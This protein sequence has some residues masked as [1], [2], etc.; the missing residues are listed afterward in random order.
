[1]DALARRLPAIAAI[2]IAAILA[3]LASGLLVRLVE[4]KSLS[5]VSQALRLGG[6]DWAQV[7]VDGLQVRIAGTA[8]S[9]AQRFRALT[10]AGTVVDSA[11]VLDQ[12]QVAAA[13]VAAPRFSIELLRNEKTVSL[14]GLVPAA[15]DRDAFLSSVRGIV[16]DGSVTD[17][18]EASGQPAPDGWDD[19]VAYGLKALAVLPRAKV[20]VAADLV[21][22]SG[23]ADDGNDKRRLES[24]LTRQAPDGMRVALAISAPRPALTPFTLR[25]LIDPAGKARFDA[26]SADTDAAR[27]R[28][29]EAAVAAGMTGKA[30]C[31]IGL[32]APSPRWGDAAALAIRAV[33]DLGAGTVTIADADVSLV[34]PAT[35]TKAVF[36]TVTG[37]LDNALPDAFSLHAVLTEAVAEGAAA[38]GDGPPDVVATL[39]G[40]GTLTMRGK[41]ADARQQQVID[42]FAKAS[43]G[44]ARVQNALRVDAAVPEGWAVRVLAGLGALKGLASGEVT[45]QPAF[46]KVTGVT[47]NAD[48]QAQVS[49]DLSATLG[50]GADFAID[51]AYD[52][53][54]DP[55]LGLPTADECV[56]DIN[57]AIAVQKINFDPGSA[58]IQSGAG[59]TL[60]KIAALMKTCG[61]YPIEIGGHT[62]SQGRQEMN[63]ALSQSRAE[64]VLEALVKRR[65][66]TD[67]LTAR[68]YG[69]EQPVADNATEAGREAN[70]R[71]AVRLVPA[72]EGTAA[73][74]GEK[75]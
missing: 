48:R 21:R 61:E 67:N 69:E 59:A 13:V 53:K 49:G 24:E 33:K 14:I 65:A 40:D 64:A 31:V 23:M 27:D 39:A 62:D 2:L 35:V 32:G 17:L 45:V 66:P 10:A 4:A 5:G 55:V 63:Q 71:I 60:D 9:E 16:G 3:T 15:M 72:D 38:S 7:Q 51:I 1:M 30:D 20:S 47:G 58:D 75:P 11:R 41:V 34:A 37:T 36:D 74:T 22:V 28:I 56:T 57:A 29:L 73:A 50:E 8:P 6:Y 44:A 54:L 43:F 42:G 26:C 18:L 46:L 70:R 25:F 19:A 68:G 52:K 12:M